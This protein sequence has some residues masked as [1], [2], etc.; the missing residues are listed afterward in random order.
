MIQS[1]NGIEVVES[2]LPEPVRVNGRRAMLQM[3]DVLLAEENNVQTIASALQHYLNEKP[4]DFFYRIVM[5]MLP[6]GAVLDE[7]ENKS[8]EIAINLVPVKDHRAYNEQKE[9]D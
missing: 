9:G 7:D 6:K 8:N 5:P 2:K 4:L 1:A 3:L